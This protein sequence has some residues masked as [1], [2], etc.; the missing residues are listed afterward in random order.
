MTTKTS[1][2]IRITLMS[3]LSIMLG[4]SAFMKFAGGEQVVE[5]FKKIGLSNQIAF[6]GSLEIVSLVLFL[7]PRTNQIGFFL[8]L[9]YLGDAS[10]IELAGG[11]PPMAFLFIAVLWITAYLKDARLFSLKQV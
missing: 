10:S 6:I 8:L 7:I 1:R 11:Q 9:S 3:I 2:V 5:G 4:M